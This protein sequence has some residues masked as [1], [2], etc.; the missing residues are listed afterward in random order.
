MIGPWQSK[1][2]GEMHSLKHALK[3]DHNEMSIMEAELRFSLLFWEKPQLVNILPCRFNVLRLDLW[4]WNVKNRNI[5]IWLMHFL[6]KM[7]LLFDGSGWY[8]LQL[9]DLDYMELFWSVLNQHILIETYRCSALGV[10]SQSLL[11]KNYPCDEK[12]A[13]VHLCGSND[14]S[15]VV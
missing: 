10:N 8:C 15:Q 6:T 1:T 2:G 14:H 3:K 5:S 4:R 7:L 13:I 12:P 11:S 9:Y